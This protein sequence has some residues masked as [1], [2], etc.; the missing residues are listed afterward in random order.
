M[1]YVVFR[2]GRSEDEPNLS[3]LH[4]GREAAEAQADAWRH[5][6][7]EVTLVDTDACSVEE[8]PARKGGGFQTVRWAAA[9]QTRRGGGS[10]ARSA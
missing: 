10:K 2:A 9:K 3:R 7:F 8:V 1:A 6:G 4:R 5:E